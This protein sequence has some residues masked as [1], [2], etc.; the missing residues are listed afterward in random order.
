MGF[1]FMRAGE[2][3]G[4]LILPWVQLAVTVFVLAVAQAFAH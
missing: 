3:S 4:P 2:P 1:G